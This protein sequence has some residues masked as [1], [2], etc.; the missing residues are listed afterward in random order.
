MFN[1]NSAEADPLE[2]GIPRIL[3]TPLSWQPWV[4]RG[5][6]QKQNG[7]GQDGG[8]PDTTT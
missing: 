2:R 4:C 8:Q 6:D 5:E 1:Q 7:E 3:G